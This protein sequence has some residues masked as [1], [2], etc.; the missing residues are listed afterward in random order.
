MVWEFFALYYPNLPTDD[1]SG[2][3]LQQRPV[4]LP[5]VQPP[6]PQDLRTGGFSLKQ[7]IVLWLKRIKREDCY[8]TFD[9][10][11]QPLEHLPPGP[12]PCRYKKFLIYSFPQ[13]PAR[14]SFM[15][16]VKQKVCSPSYSISCRLSS[17]SVSCTLKLL[18]QGD[19]NF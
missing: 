7:C 2:V 9:F 5:F 17:G 6:D 18:N 12:P 11:F 4:S 13:F 10:I 1:I 19:N 14:Q 15:V 16:S 8:D 3:Q